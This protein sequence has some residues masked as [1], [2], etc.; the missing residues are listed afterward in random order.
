M[1]SRRSQRLLPRTRQPPF[2]EITRSRPSRLVSLLVRSSFE[3]VDYSVNRNHHILASFVLRHSENV[4][5][6]PLGD[7]H[8]P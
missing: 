6:A 7:S 8:A 3:Y 2:S 4:H 5:F 1:V